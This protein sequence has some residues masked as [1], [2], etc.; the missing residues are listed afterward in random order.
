MWSVIPPTVA[1]VLSIAFIGWVNLRLALGLLVMA[2]ILGAGIFLL[3]RRGTPLH[4]RYAE[5]AAGVDGEL[6]DVISNFN[7]MRAFGATG[8]EQFRLGGII[9]G[10]MASRRRSLFYLEH[11]RLIH[12]VLTAL[13]TAS[14]VAAGIRLWLAGH[15][16]VGDIVL[17]TSLAFTI[18]HGTRDLAVALVDVTQYIS[19][20][21]EA[22][23][24]LLLEQELPDLIGAPA[25]PP[26]PCEVTFEGVSFAYPGRAP[27]LENFDLTL[28][29]GERVGLVGFSGA[30][31][32]TVLSLLQRF[33]DVRDGRILVDGQDIRDV[34]KNSLRDVLA[35]VPQ[36][37]SLFNRTV[38]ENLCYGRPNTTEAEM[39]AAAE[40][41]RCREFIEALPQGF[42]TM[43]GDRGVMLSGG[44]RQRL[45]IARALLKNAPILLLD[46]ATSALDT[47]SE[48][49][50]QAALDD[51][52]KGRTVIAIAHRL[53]TLRRFD[54]IIVMDR[55]RIVDDGTPSELARR[56]GPYRDL[57]DRQRMDHELA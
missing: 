33:H 9:G 23:R 53:S 50:I 38:R 42:D 27:V 32:S 3:A 49:L 21:D 28:T 44:Q 55:G 45:A 7:V 31:K 25:M 12:A 19:R 52:M 17:V 4:R 54:R 40:T 29:P 22:T 15:A 41:A 48:Q 24:A 43:V 11:L 34:T 26:G 5:D 20:L 16:T 2:L 8:R 35:L 51:L 46:E 47:E 30:G 1:V 36:D 6:V 39:L 57:L 14:V 18:L 13:L 10:E 37:I 56:A